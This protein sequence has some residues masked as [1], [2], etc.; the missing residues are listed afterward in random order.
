[1]LENIFKSVQEASRTLGLVSEDKVNR[2]LHSLADKTAKS[3][4]AI[5]AENAKDLARMEESDPKYD[6][7]KLTERRI[8]DIVE[9]I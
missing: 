7:L 4:S 5:L 6:R 2:I 1:M 8:L 3:I 9:D